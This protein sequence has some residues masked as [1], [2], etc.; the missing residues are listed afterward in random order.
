MSLCQPPLTSLH[1]PYLY[2]HVKKKKKKKGQIHNVKL[3][4]SREYCTVLDRRNDDT[5]ISPT[6]KK[7][8][9]RKTTVCTLEIKQHVSFHFTP[10]HFVTSS[11]RLIFLV[12]LCRC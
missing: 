3:S 6:K 7:K 11:W 1:M 9:T 4:I 5:E 8:K 2:L 12:Q 10:S